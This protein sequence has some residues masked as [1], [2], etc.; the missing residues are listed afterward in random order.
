MIDRASRPVPD[1][2]FRLSQHPPID[3]G[4]GGLSAFPRPPAAPVPRLALSPDEAAASLGISRDFLDQHVMPELRVVRRG[5]RRLVPV[6]ELE[7]WLSAEAALP[8]RD[9]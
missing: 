7:R 2:R 9:D 1:P 3:D 4:G 5:R 8:L 6:R